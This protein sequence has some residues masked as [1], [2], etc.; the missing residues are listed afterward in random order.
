VITPKFAKKGEM[1]SAMLVLATNTHNGQ[2]DKGGV[3]YIL[4]PLKV[5]HYLKSDDE[6]LMCIALG[7]DLVE[8]HG[9]VVTYHLLR[10]MGFTERVIDGIRCLTKV[11]GET[12]EEYK[13]KVKSNIDAIRVKMADLRHNTDIRRLKGTT[14]K[15]IKRTIQYHNFYMEL[16]EALEQHA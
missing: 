11:P 14:E 13:A 4:H 5:M 15:D 1:L 6:E 8:D 3:P 10:E 7:H 9:K 12:Y 16:K 2:F